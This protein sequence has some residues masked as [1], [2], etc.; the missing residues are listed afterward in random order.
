[1]QIFHQLERIEE[2]PSILDRMPTLKPS[3]P[4]P[5]KPPIYR[6]LFP[7]NTPNSAPSSEVEADPSISS[8]STAPP[9]TT[10]PMMTSSISE[11]VKVFL[12]CL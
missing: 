4:T 11:W 2:E 10:R 7:E 3:I 12:P 8:S 9:P 1:M 5:G 6:Q